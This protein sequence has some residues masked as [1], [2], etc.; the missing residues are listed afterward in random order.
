[1][2]KSGFDP[3]NN[4]RWNLARSCDRNGVNEIPA[5][6]ISPANHNPPW[7]IGYLGSPNACT[8]DNRTQEWPTSQTY[9]DWKLKN[10][11]F[12]GGE[13]HTCFD[14]APYAVNDTL[15][16]AF[17]AS[18]IGL[19]GECF[20]LQFD[21]EWANDVAR[22]THR[23][24]KGKTLIVMISNAGVGEGAF[25][26]MFPGG[27][28]GDYDGFSV[29]LGLSP[30][31]NLRDEGLLGYRVGGLITE[32]EQKDLNSGWRAT[33]EEWQTCLRSKCHRTFDNQHPSLLRGCLWS[34]DWFMAANNP[35]ANYI[36]VA[37]PQ[38]LK[39]KYRSTI[40]SEPPKPPEGHTGGFCVDGFCNW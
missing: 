14:M 11:N 5:F 21:G 34:A 29:Q 10:P 22:P 20:M 8:P 30:E 31:T 37:C 15:A 28:L 18:G 33:L 4:P 12:P 3:V 39:D 27:G 13:S 23:A 6:Y 36:K 40:D 16:Y 19:C 9:A 25:D 26:I 38:Y 17:A 2:D 1:L 7:H 24:L 32:C 35:N